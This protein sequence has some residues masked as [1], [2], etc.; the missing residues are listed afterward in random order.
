MNIEH[1]VGIINS[2]Y[3]V[4][5]YKLSLNIYSDLLPAKVRAMK[6]QQQSTTAISPLG[7]GGGEG[8]TPIYYLYGYVPPNGV[9][10]LKLLI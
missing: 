10:I 3:Q 9:V 5:Q 2:E 4:N 7:G 8:G 6:P 1:I